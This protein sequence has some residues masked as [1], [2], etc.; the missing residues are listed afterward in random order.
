M[1]AYSSYKLKGHQGDI[2]R[3]GRRWRLMEYQQFFF[4]TEIERLAGTDAAKSCMDVGR[5]A[6]Y[7]F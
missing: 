6:Q 3:F 1:L 4:A 5:A 7:D 2:D